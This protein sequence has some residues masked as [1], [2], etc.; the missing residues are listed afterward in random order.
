MQ[1]R[2]DIK[3][4]N[5]LSIIGFGC[6]RFPRDSDKIDIN[7]TEQLIIKAV[8][9]GINYFDTAYA[10]GGSEDVLGQII[11][12]NNL[13]SKIFLATKMPL[14]KCGSYDDFDSL[15]HEQLKRLHTDYIDYYLLHNLSDI[16]LWNKLCEL[17][18]E[19]WIKEK[20]ESSQIKS[21]G[22][23][24]HGIH[25]EFLKLLDVYN[26][27][28]C[29]IQYN[30]IN[31]N[32]QAGTE[33]LKKAAGKGLPVIIMEPLLG[34]KL[35]TGLPKKAVQIFKEAHGAAQG[36]LSPAAWALRWIWNHG[37]VTVVLS[38]MNAMTQLEENIETAQNALPNMLTKVE[39]DT[40]ESVIKIIEDSYKV[41]CTGCNYCMP[42]P[43]NVNIPACFTA[44]NVSFA[45]GKV[46]GFLQYLTGTGAMEPVNNYSAVKCIECG[47]CEK[48][49]PQH[50]PIIKSLKDVAERMEPF[51]SVYADF[52]V[53]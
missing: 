35:A 19:R 4:G 2:M 7:R 29:Q 37:E 44:Y 53:S 28:F 15:F 42:C 26:W 11:A 36:A 21:V 51:F 6:M 38:G 41:P 27:D 20:K 48:K 18:I 5:K 52:V 8:Q 17:G 34:G 31:T 46:A 13:R 23:S 25:E 9:D 47:A 3:S 50:I 39:T 14:D 45:I 32:Y 40:Y 30:Y 22:F 16:N 10:Y 12:K 43:Q 33:G 24:F 49:C 1:Y